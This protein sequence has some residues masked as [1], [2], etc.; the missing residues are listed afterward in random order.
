MTI[1]LSVTHLFAAPWAKQKTK[2]SAC[3]TFSI[4]RNE[5]YY[6]EQRREIAFQQWLV[7]FLAPTLLLLPTHTPK[8]PHWNICTDGFSFT[9][10][11]PN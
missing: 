2:S 5:N 8:F 11:F 1:I 4:H 6:S 7:G 9:D 3:P 10:N